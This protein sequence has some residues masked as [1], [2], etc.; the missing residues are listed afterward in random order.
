MRAPTHQTVKLGRG[1]HA[2]PSEGACVMELASMLAGESFDDHPKSVCPVIGM[3]LRA[4]ND[5]VDDA[6][7]Q[8]LYRWAAEVV[9]TRDRGA[10]RRRL[11]LCLQHFGIEAGA[12]RRLFRSSLLRAVGRA[13]LDEGRVATD[14]SHVAFLGLLGRLVRVE[15][16]ASQR[17]RVAVA[18]MPDEP[19]TSTS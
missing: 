2:S 6:R 14:Y 9:G 18:P 15:S 1:K 5:G 4:Y 12:W 8:E 7:R 10:R 3:V 19:A 11:D 17:V 16:A 13:A